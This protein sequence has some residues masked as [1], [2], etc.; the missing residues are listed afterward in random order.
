MVRIGGADSGVTRVGRREE[1][2]HLRLDRGMQT[3]PGGV[4]RDTVERRRMV[5]MI[6]G[7]P[8]RYQWHLGRCG[9]MVSMVVSMDP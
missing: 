6:A 8:V 2:H 7:D 3:E 1:G 5:W 9:G 4:P